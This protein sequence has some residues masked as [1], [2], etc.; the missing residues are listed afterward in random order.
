MVKLSR[1]VRD[2]RES[3]AVNAVVNLFGF[4]DDHT[5]L[6]KSGEIGVVLRVHGV[7]SE[8][9]D[10][11]QLEEVT[12]RFEASLRAFDENYRLYQYFVKRNCAV[13]PHRTNYENPIVH[14]AIQS[15]IAYLEAKSDQLYELTV[16]FV[17]LYEGFAQKKALSAKLANLVTNPR[18]ALPALLSSDKT[19]LLM[20]DELGRGGDLLRNKVNGFILQLS[21]SMKVDLLPKEEQFQ[22]FR[23][24]LNPSPVKADSVRLKHNTHLDFFVSDS[25]IEGHRGHLR[26]DDYY[27][28]VLTMKEP[29][30]K[31]RANLLH[32]LQEVPSCA[33]VAL[34][35]QTQGNGAIRKLINSKRRHF[36]NSKTGM[37]NYLNHQPLA[38]DQML[39]DD[40]AAALVQNLGLCLKELEVQGNYFGICSLSVVLYDQERA[41]VERAVQETFKVFSTVD[42]TLLEERYNLLNSFLAILPGNH[43]YNLR[44]LYLLNTNYADLS[45]LFC[46]QSGE[47][48]NAHLNDEY[49]AI[50]ETNQ[51]SPYYLN[52]HYQDTAHSLIFGRTRSGKSFLLNYVITNLQKYK[53]FTYIFDIGGSY[54]SLTRLFGGSYLK[55]GLKGSGFSIN[56]FALEPTPENQNF[57]YS[58]VKVLAESGGGLPL[59]L[60]DEREIYEG[61]SNIYALP[62]EVR[63]LGSLAGLLPKRISQRLKRWIDDGQYANLFDNV[64]DTLTLSTFQ[65][66]DFQ[67]MEQYQE[68]LEPLLFYVL[69]RA[70]ASIYAPEHATVFK[71]SVFDETWRFIKNR[72]IRNYIDEALR[73][74]P[75]HNAALVM[76]THANE[77]F[78]KAE[79]LSTVV[80]GCATKIFLAN[81]GLDPETYAKTFHLNQREVQN[82]ASLIPKQQL[83]VKRPDLAK[84]VNLHVSDRD[85]WLYTN[86]P[87]DNARRR[88]AFE[89]YGFER[90]LEV[91]AASRAK[92]SRLPVPA[93]ELVTVS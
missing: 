57:Q 70:R 42:S 33:I 14:E 52:L 34:E 73:T 55:V 40:G 31:T 15:R 61:V 93:E 1:I 26:I 43:R 47:R 27:V 82:I 64:D 25:A 18:K 41:Q 10:A 29:P 37:M 8:C 81:P 35:W 46:A 69:H 65:T 53:P 78:E 66:F 44:Y 85:Y 88:E 22:F 67:E 56:P 86:S 63:R 49:L 13:L 83:L 6:T 71:V 91:L 51:R 2:Y 79:L 23:R 75:K 58:F 20:E 92:W 62:R 16:Y 84:V 36:H 89:R 74:W 39:V 90:G 4:I 11:E 21:D 32:L 80:E 38:Q 68:V 87:Y 50:F 19:I 17:I 72:T 9:L 54:E 59:S 48:H 3:G 45:F 5:F 60:D 28:K 7:D 77:E 24:L 30:G 76:A 12:R